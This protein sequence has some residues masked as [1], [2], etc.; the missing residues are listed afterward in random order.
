MLKNHDQSFVKCALYEMISTHDLQ[1]NFVILIE[2]DNCTAQYNSVSYKS[3]N[4]IRY[5]SDVNNKNI[6]YRWAW[7]GR[8]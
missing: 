7:K 4:I 6:W 2:S 3:T 5:V 1:S 8:D